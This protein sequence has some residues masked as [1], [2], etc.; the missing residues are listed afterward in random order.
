MDIQL[1]LCSFLHYYNNVDPSL[2]E[3]KQN[4]KTKM[5]IIIIL[6]IS[7]NFYKEENVLI[8]VHFY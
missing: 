5:Y 7:F 4:K 3:K 1:F 2:W 8:V 6:K